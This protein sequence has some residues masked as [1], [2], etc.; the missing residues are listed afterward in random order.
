MKAV[1]LEIDVLYCLTITMFYIVSCGSL[2]S[3]L[4]VDE[5]EAPFRT[6]ADSTKK[7]H[8]RHFRGH[9]TLS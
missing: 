1:A 7:C 6:N 3:F 9:K 5:N 8:M 2:V 4:L